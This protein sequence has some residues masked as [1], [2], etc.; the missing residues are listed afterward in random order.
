MRDKYEQAAAE[1]YTKELIFM[2]CPLEQ[3]NKKKH[4]KTC[5]DYG[6][7]SNYS[8]YIKVRFEYNL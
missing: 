1:F 5:Q 8:V 4:F 3:R 6:I 2:L 7:C